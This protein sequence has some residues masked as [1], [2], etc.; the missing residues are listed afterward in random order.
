VQF[1]DIIGQESVK[2]NLLTIVAHNRISQAYLFSGNR[3][4]GKLALAI[5]FAQYIMCKD[6]ANGD[7]CGVCPS[8]KKYAKI[9]HP[10][11]HLVFPVIKKK[12]SSP[13]ISDNLINEFRTNLL[14]NPYIDINEWHKEIGDGK[15]VGLIYTEESESI[16]K[17]ISLKPYESDYKVMIIWHPEL[18]HTTCANKILKILE[19]PPEKTIFI[20]VSNDSN[21]LL[22]TIYSRTQ[23]IEIPNIDDKIIIDCLI[24]KYAISREDAITYSRTS[25]GSWLLA[26]QQVQATEETE[27][28]FE[29]FVFLMRTCWAR[30][31]LDLISWSKAISALGRERQKS[32]LTYSVKMS[33]ESFM[34]NLNNDSLVFANKREKEFMQRFSP[35]I[36]EDNLIFIYQELN[37]AYADIIRNGNAKLIFLDLSLKLVKVIRP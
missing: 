12:S 18:M 3:G 19:E 32:F 16:I 14:K 31:V 6:K 21:K 15:K 30:K 1:K 35:F 5:A 26:N 34:N 4:I 27:Y 20:L 2:Q 36:N 7:S 33:R 13:L 11:L 23:K 17:K 25:A 28:N 29:Q 37:K 24:K 22:D 9:E 10:D 8:C